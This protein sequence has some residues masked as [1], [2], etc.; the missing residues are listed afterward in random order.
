M[1]PRS[2]VFT[3]AS[4]SQES[5][6]RKNR[7]YS[8]VQPDDLVTGPSMFTSDIRHHLFVANA[9]LRSISLANCYFALNSVTS[10]PLLRVK[11]STRPMRLR[12]SGSFEGASVSEVLF[13]SCRHG[14]QPHDSYLSLTNDD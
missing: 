1:G 12:S 4:F 13:F 10:G 14:L 2:N 11:C 9:R 5:E 8:A 6:T 3:E 7:K